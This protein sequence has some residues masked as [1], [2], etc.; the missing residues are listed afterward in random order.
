VWNSNILHK[1]WTIFLRFISTAIEIVNSLVLKRKLRE[2]NA[3]NLV[4]ATV[5]NA[6]RNVK[7]L[8]RNSNLYHISSIWI[9]NLREC[10][11]SSAHLILLIAYYPNREYSSDKFENYTRNLVRLPPNCFSTATVQRNVKTLVWNSNLYQISHLINFRSDNPQSDEWRSVSTSVQ[12]CLVTQ[13][14][15][16]SLA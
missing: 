4:S 6:T 12:T 5:L 10:S 3:T 11:E 9:Q 8:V 16:P 1:I 13:P 14:T 7:T 15:V 2:L